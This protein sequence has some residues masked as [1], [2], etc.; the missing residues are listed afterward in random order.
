[1]ITCENCPTPGLCCV[2]VVPP[3]LV[4]DRKEHDK[5]NDALKF[6]CKE[7]YFIC[8]KLDKDGK[9]SDYE[10]RPKRCR[11]W[12]CNGNPHSFIFPISGERRKED[13]IIQRP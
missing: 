9:C 11:E 12:F 5:G 10:N 6:V 3:I 8:D 7:P 2:F 1:M 4:K 13:G